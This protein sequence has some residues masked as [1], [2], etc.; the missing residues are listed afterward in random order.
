M[1]VEKHVDDLIPGFALG[2]L[3]ASELVEA[4]SHLALC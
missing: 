3:D 2:C 4:E 1:M